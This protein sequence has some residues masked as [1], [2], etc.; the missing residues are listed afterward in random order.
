M[1]GGMAPPIEIESIGGGLAFE[2]KE[3]S[4]AS[5]MRCYQCAK[6]S[7]GCPVAA[8]GDL[9]PHE[10]VR[11]VQLGLRDE[12]LDMCT[13]PLRL[14]LTATK[15]RGPGALRLDDFVG[16]IVY[17]LRVDELVGEFLA[18]APGTAADNV[19]AVLA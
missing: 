15:P 12:V 13:A 6:C 4:G 5:P 10:L 1:T 8:R 16:P 9:K 17:E 3:R 18:Q 19:D 7:S 11:L 14:G 2:V